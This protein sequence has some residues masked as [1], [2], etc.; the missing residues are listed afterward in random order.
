MP[1]PDPS[2]ADRLTDDSLVW[3]REFLGPTQARYA[4][5]PIDTIPELIDESQ[6]AA[7]ALEALARRWRQDRLET[8]VFAHGT[9]PPLRVRCSTIAVMAGLRGTELADGLARELDAD[10]L[11]PAAAIA[12]SLLELVGL[13][14]FWREHVPRL[15][16]EDTDGLDVLTLR[17]LL[18]SR[19]LA[20]QGLMSNFG[21]PELMASAKDQMGGH[22]GLDYGHLCDLAHPNLLARNAIDRD[23]TLSFRR[24]GIDDAE[25][26]LLLKICGQGTRRIAHNAVWLLDWV[27]VPGTDMD[28]ATSPLG[29]RD[30]RIE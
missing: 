6:R 23:G 16:R 5:S 26:E 20:D 17:I 28:F 27:D 13:S 24:S 11:F 12:R 21:I 1:G 14:C 19:T 29:K 8:E 3:L 2:S 4:G 22:V 18:G 25:A 7:A 15:R 30:G 9:P 10:A